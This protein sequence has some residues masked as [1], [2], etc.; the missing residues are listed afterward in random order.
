ME[1]QQVAIVILQLKK[2]RINKS[3]RNSE[4]GGNYL[5]DSNIYRDRRN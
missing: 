2:W 4:K 3:I 5:D 1:L